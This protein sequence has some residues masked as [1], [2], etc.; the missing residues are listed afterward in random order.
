MRD[1]EAAIFA[2]VGVP[3]EPAHSPHH[4]PVVDP[5]PARA[6]SAQQ[7]DGIA[8]AH[9]ASQSGERRAQLADDQPLDAA[10]SPKMTTAVAASPPRGSR[11]SQ[12]APSQAASWE[13]NFTFGSPSLPRREPSPVRQRITSERGAASS[14]QGAA[15]PSSAAFARAGRELGLAG[16]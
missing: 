3:D 8:G 7:T 10:S 12:A 13:D 9:A 6:D 11:V 16:L 15:A 1:L 4:S 14:R 2:P 5:W